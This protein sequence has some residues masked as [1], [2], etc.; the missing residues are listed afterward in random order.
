[1]RNLMLMTA[2]VTVLPVALA[3]PAEAQNWRTMTSARQIQDREPLHAVIHYGAGTLTVSPAE[4][5]Y[6]YQMELRYDEEGAGPLVEYDADDRTLRLGTNSGEFNRRGVR[7]AG[8][9]TATIRLTKEVPVD[10]EIKFGAGKADIELGGISL[11]NLEIGTGASETTVRFSSPNPIEAEE[12]TIE[13]GAADLKVYGLGNARAARIEFQGGV[14]ATVL[15]FSG[16]A[17]N[18]EAKVEMGIGSLVLR[19]PRSHGVRMERDSFLTNFTVPGMT[20][21]GDHFISS[22][23][24][25]ASQ[26]LEIELSAALGSVDIEWID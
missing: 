7:S 17:R 26:K 5:P 4:S 12:V 19:I 24:E 25:N 1:M 18:M 20:R 16:A 23:W 10:L 11:E 21:E 14:G 8:E 22:N 3:L 15:D 6:L 2:L 9:A 13:A